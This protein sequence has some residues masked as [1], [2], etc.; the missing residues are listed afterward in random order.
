MIDFFSSF[1]LYRILQ[2]R[3]NCQR[4][5]ELKQFLQFSCLD[6]TGDLLQLYCGIFQC[7]VILFA[8]KLKPPTDKLSFYYINVK[9]FKKSAFWYDNPKPFPENVWQNELTARYYYQAVF[10]SHKPRQIGC[11]GFVRLGRVRTPTD[12][13]APHGAKQ[14]TLGFL[15][16]HRF[17]HQSDSQRKTP[18]KRI[19][20][21][22]VH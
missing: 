13:F 10:F 17:N 4:W 7:M 6:C 1:L 9:Y 22:E 21:A 20:L 12:S 3:V 5:R 8:D 18:D 14:G 16:G 15:A 2:I 11:V 19:A